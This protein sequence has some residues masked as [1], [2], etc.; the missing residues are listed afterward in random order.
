MTKFK[1]TKSFKR[2]RKNLAEQKIIAIF[3]EGVSE[4]Q[5]FKMLQRKYS[6]S[7]IGAHKLNIKQFGGK[8]GVDLIRA[9]VAQKRSFK[10]I[11]E[12]YIVFDCDNLNH[13]QIQESISLARKKNIHIIFSRTNFE[14]WILMHFE[15]VNRAY[16]A[17]QLNQILSDEKHFDIKKSNY[18]HFKGSEYTPFLEDRIKTAV[19][20]ANQLY[21]KNNN[22]ILDN[23]YTNV[24][25]NLIPIFGRAD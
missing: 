11:D 21:K 4:L 20:N 9:A 7:N 1:R 17:L 2:S 19:K 25:E 3:C 8:K 24:Q 5:Y 18:D 12:T 14:I 16:S 23:P 13:T 10:N 6:K 15:Q 22:I